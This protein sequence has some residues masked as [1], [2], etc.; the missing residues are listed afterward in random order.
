MRGIVFS[1]AA[2]KDRQEITTFTVERFG[3][4]Q[5]RELRH[6]FEVALK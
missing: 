2:R 4:E 1:Q 6:R 3:L 5:A